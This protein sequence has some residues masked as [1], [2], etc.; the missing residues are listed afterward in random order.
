MNECQCGLLIK[1]QKYLQLLH[2]AVVQKMAEED[3]RDYD[4]GR[5]GAGLYKSIYVNCLILRKNSETRAILNHSV[6]CQRSD[7]ALSASEI[8]SLR[9]SLLET[10]FIAEAR[11][12]WTSEFVIVVD[13]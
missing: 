5:I 1:L 11:R 10:I 8:I 9:T 13:E 7:D 3:G 6:N 12:A 2:L 4:D